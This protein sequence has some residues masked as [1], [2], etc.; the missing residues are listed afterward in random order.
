MPKRRAAGITLIEL[1]IVITVVAILAVA[2]IPAMDPQYQDQVD[3]AARI[4]ASD[5]DY[6][7]SL[8]VTNASTYCVTFDAAN[9]RYILEHGNV[10][11]PSLDAL[12]KSPFGHP[13]DPA[14]QRIVRLDELPRLG[15]PARI[16]QVVRVGGTLEPATSVEFQPSGGTT[17]NRPTVVV[18]TTGQ[19]ADKRRCLVVV[20]PVTGLAS[21]GEDVNRLAAMIPNDALAAVDALGR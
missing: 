2:M 5:L 1:L 6:A 16:D 4:V 21:V 14:T 20:N 12:P 19:G 8:A 10:L 17:D 11:K 3:S 9:N 15:V 7:R 13:D 18:L